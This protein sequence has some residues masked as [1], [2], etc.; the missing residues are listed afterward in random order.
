MMKIA[1]DTPFDKPIEPH[2]PAS[3]AY[4]QAYGVTMR[5][6]LLFVSGAAGIAGIATVTT[7]MDLRAYLTFAIFFLSYG[8]GQALTDCFQTDTDALSAP[9]RPL[10]RG[11]LQRKHVL[12]TSV[13][14][15][16]A[17][18]ALLVSL[19]WRTLALAALA[20]MGLRTYTWFK[21]RWWGGPLYNAWIVALIPPM[22]ALAAGGGTFEQLVTTL[23]LP[24]LLATITFAYANF[25][26]V[27]YLK[28]VWAD[29]ETGYNTFPVRFGWTATRFVSHGLAILSQGALLATL[30]LH[31]AASVA[32]LGFALAVTMTLVGQVAAHHVNK[33]EDAHWPIAYTVRSFVASALALALFYQPSLIAFA[34]MFYVAFE[35]VL[36]ARPAKTQI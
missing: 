18:A 35:V 25:V 31:T 17:C 8:L 11:E 23:A 3:V 5:P 24:G 2:S 14:G 30:F 19:N 6:Y 33:E 1:D 15:L 34:V 26:L 29:R 12:W 9:Y 27:G 20:I 10:V 21:R 22:A 32:Y 36:W 13:G 28:D 7:H 16:V 4:W